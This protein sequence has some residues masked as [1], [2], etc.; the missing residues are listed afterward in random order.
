M[1]FLF[2]FGVSI[3]VPAVGWGL[4]FLS[5]KYRH[6]A[7]VFESR[8]GREAKEIV[9]TPMTDNKKDIWI[10]CITILSY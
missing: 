1:L 2:L 4:M 3:I 10:H 8:D 6:M 9:P 5:S 7:Q